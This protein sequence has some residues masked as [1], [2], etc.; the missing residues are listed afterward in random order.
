MW[1]S[2]VVVVVAIPVPANRVQW[3][4]A[5]GS[6]VCWYAVR[7]V[8]FPSIS[9]TVADSLVVFALPRDGSRRSVHAEEVRHIGVVIRR[10]REG[11]GSEYAEIDEELG[12]RFGYHRAAAVSMDGSCI[13][14]GLAH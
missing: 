14:G 12:Y 1:I 4:T 5:A 6:A 8:S 9:R 10:A 13:P 3:P 11:M 2:L 7:S